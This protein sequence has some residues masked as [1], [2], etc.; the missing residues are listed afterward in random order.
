MTTAPATL[1]ALEQARE[2]LERVRGRRYSR[3]AQLKRVITA[4]PGTP[5]PT[6]TFDRPGVRG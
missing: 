5:R 4:K 6:G 3:N 1:A 2:R